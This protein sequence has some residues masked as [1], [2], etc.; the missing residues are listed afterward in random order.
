MDDREMLIRVEQQMKDATQN[1]LQIMTDLK[2]LFRRIENDSKTVSQ[3]KGDFQVFLQTS[4][5]KMAE[6]ERRLIEQTEVLKGM[7]S[8]TKKD[9]ED[10]AKEFKTIDDSFNTFKGEMNGSIKAMKW[11]F[12]AIATVVAMIN[13]FLV[14]LPKL[15]R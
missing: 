5:M 2:D 14:I 11:V 9:K 10:R 6:I 13:L 3:L 12:G 7:Q 4:S 1:Q 8:D 15:V